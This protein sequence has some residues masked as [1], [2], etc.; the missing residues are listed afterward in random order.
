MPYA[1][2]LGKAQLLPFPPPLSLVC[3]AALWSP[4]TS[5][6]PQARP[7][8][9]PE[10]AHGA[11]LLYSLGVGTVGRPQHRAV[12]PPPCAPCS[13]PP[14]R[15]QG[16]LRVPA[17]LLR[18]GHP[19]H[20][21][22]APANHRAPTAPHLAMGRGLVRRAL[23]PSSPRARAQAGSFPGIDRPRLGADPAGDC[24]WGKR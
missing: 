22:A 5:G 17:P 7:S 2:G 15:P 10:P 13:S 20:P 8:R 19:I 18:R 23:A 3:I 14:T 24:G 16:A 4:I 12:P 9:E 1:G 6:P 11:P 21:A